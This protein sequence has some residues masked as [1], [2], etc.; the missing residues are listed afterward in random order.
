[1]AKVTL[2]INGKLVQAESGEMLLAVIKRLGI[3][4]P[5][6][7][8]H[9]A[10][11]PYGACRLCTVEIT[12]KEWDGWKNQVTSCLYP[13]EEGLIVSTH[14]PELIDIRKTLIDLFLARS[15]KAKLIRDMAAEYGITQTSYQEIP[16]G[17]D[18]ILCGL[19]TRICDQMGF[20]AISSVNRGHGKEIAPPLGEP[21]PDCVGCLACAQICPTDF[22]KWEDKAGRRRIWERDFE[23]VTCEQT[24]QPTITKAFAEHLVKH[25]GIPEDYFRI[26][27]LSHRK[28]LALT[29]GKISQW[30]RAARQEEE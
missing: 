27:D 24:G 13:V 2:T 6:T 18:C 5:H 25:R 3:D 12:K 11:E 4:V 21:P 30:D 19:C 20:H 22:I 15:P 23:L 17:D 10:V 14:T 8:D 9:N 7:C 1:M 28:E 26:N 29:M 16:D